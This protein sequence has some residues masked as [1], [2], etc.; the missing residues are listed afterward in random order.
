MN[1]KP[2]AKAFLTLFLAIIFL[3]ALSFINWSDIT[4]SVSDSGKESSFLKD[5]NL[6]S[7]LLPEDTTATDGDVDIDPALKAAM[8]AEANK[9]K[10]IERIDSTT[11]A[12]I[13]DTAIIDIKPAKVNGN[14]VIEDYSIAQKG[15]IN[16]KDAISKCSTRPARIAVIGDSYIEGDIFT[17][18]I[19]ELLQTTYGG[20]GVGYV[21]MDCITKGFRQSVKHSAKGWQTSTL[22]KNK[23]GEHFILPGLYCTSTVN[24]Y[25][26]YSGSTLVKNADR[27]DNSKFI[28]ISP[29]NAAIDINCGEGWKTYNIVGSNSLQCISIDKNTDK[30]EMRTNS[31]S[32]IALGVWLGNNMGVSVDCMSLRGYSGI[33]HTKINQE[34]SSQLSQH[35]DYDLIIIEYGLNVLSGKNKNYGFYENYMVNVVNKIRSC[36]PNADIIILGCGD[37]GIKRGSSIQSMSTAPYLIASQRNI[38]RRTQCF[39][40]DTREA[41]GGE[42][43]IIEWCNN[44]EINKDYIHLSFKGGERLANLFVNSLNSAIK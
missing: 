3:I 8:E 2:G 18:S 27:W 38:A 5:F 15:L 41:M 26:S 1:I 28:F 42:N 37:R 10:Y 23:G 19:R 33:S 31:N 16:F 36:H 44:N 35:I 17:Q 6:I 20:K 11:G 12:H 24:S 4:K 14:V 29:N 39:F 25:A 13:V 40:W 7:Q 9:P 34:L 22:M 32:I 21:A 30:F 43:A